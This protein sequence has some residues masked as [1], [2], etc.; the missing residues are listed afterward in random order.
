MI[1][2]TV[3]G[4][5]VRSVKDWDIVNLLIKICDWEIYSLFT[6]FLYCSGK[7]AEYLNPEALHKCDGSVGIR[8]EI[9][10]PLLI[11]NQFFQ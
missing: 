1:T 4:K 8:Q 7:A 2:V 9:K 6:Y 10:S 5:R 3:D 11:L